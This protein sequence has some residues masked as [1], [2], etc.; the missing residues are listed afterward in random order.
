MYKFNI[1]IY[2]KKCKKTKNKTK[3]RRK[4]VYK[5]RRS[6]IKSKPLDKTKIEQDVLD[7]TVINLS[8]KTIDNGHKFVFYLGQS[9]AVTPKEPDRKKLL[10][11]VNK[12]ATSL[13]M[14]YIYSRIPKKVQNDDAQ[15]ITLNQRVKQM[16]KDLKTTPPQV[17]NISNS[18]NHAL[19]LFI[20]NVKKQIAEHPGKFTN[21]PAPKNVDRGTLSAIQEMKNWNDTVI[22][23]FDKGTGF[24][25]LDKQDYINRVETALSDTTTFRLIENSTVAIN[26]TITAVKSWILKY[27]DEPGMSLNFMEWVKPTED[28]T[29]GVNYMNIK[30]HKPEKNYPGRLISTGCNSYIKNLAIFTAQELKKVGLKYCLKDTKDFLH[31][32]Q[33]VNES[34]SLKNKTVYHV[35]FDVEAMFPSISKEMGLDACRKH[36]DKREVKL[37]S[38]DCVVD[39]LELTLDNN[40]TTFNGKMYV[41]ISG[42]AM[43]PNNACDYADVSLD[44]L[45]NLVHSCED[46]TNPVFF[47]RFRDDIYV[48]WTDTL[49][50]LD[51]FHSWLNN[52]HPNL[53]FTMST[54]SIEG[55]EFLDLFVYTKNDKIETRVYSKPSDSHSYLLPQ[56]CHPTH[57]AENIPQGVA[58]RV[59]TNCSEQSEYDKCKAE[60]T[61]YLKN[62]NYDHDLICKAFNK[63]ETLDRSTV[64]SRGKSS[65]TGKNDRCF[66]LVCDFNPALPPVGRIVNQ[67]KFILNLDPSLKKVILPEKV[68]VSY[69]GNSTIKE[70]LVPSKLREDSNPRSS[71][72]FLS[73]EVSETLGNV[74]VRDPPQKVDEEEGGCFHCKSRCKACRLFILETKTAKSFHSDFIVNIKGKLSCDSVGVIYLINDKICRRSSVGSTIN[75]F[76]TRWANHK[77]HIK[78][79]IH[80]CEISMHF[81]SD[82]HEIAKEPLKVF[83]NELSSHLEII[84]IEKVHFETDLFD[85][86]VKV[87]KDR[88]SYWQAQ[89]NTLESFGGLNKRDSKVEIKST[90]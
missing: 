16:E 31:K 86:K 55:T 66:P 11:D 7:K 73:T 52:Y 71:R 60:F 65:T 76:K 70:T 90:I 10:D 88:E 72:D 50:K 48:P 77:S 35:S 18:G 84:L 6:R 4:P 62:R 69:R 83:D 58:H 40:L 74:I 14:G 45:D 20:N 29:P 30:A 81:N 59:Y 44:I 3:R 46:I 36:L 24:F 64:I 89:L 54:P 34:G 27:I 87:L 57:V 80:S 25:I 12:W 8:S 33:K 49:D 82:F 41:Q 42:T 5:H 13:R 22:R 39:G 38:T 9:F 17:K 37:F 2:V 56:S 85:D 21:K 75:K 28:N 51:Q 79:N 53:K 32:I 78:N 43:G 68:F 63:A 19:E 15:E 23:V 26:N 61:S 47:G 1:Y 67:N